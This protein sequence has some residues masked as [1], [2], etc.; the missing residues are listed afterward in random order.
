VRLGSVVSYAALLWGCACPYPNSPLL[1]ARA[2]P[3]SH[4]RPVEL[5]RDTKLAVIGDVQRTSW[6]ERCL[7]CR[8]LN[9]RPQRSLRDD[10]G[11]REF[12]ALVLLGDMAF[13]GSDEDW[14][15][16]DAWLAPLLV[17]R[18][19]LPLVP[20][21]GNHDYYAGAAPQV[22]R[23]FPALDGSEGASRYAVRWG[24]VR[25][26]VLD[27][28]RRK[29]E[30]SSPCIRSERVPL[31]CNDGWQRQLEWLRRE[32]AEVDASSTERGA[33]LFVH[34]SPYTRSPWVQP[35]QHDA[36]QVAAELFRSRRGLAL[37]SA[38]AH[39]F[40]R[41]R[42]VRD[43]RDLRAP[44]YFLVSAGGGGPRPHA[45]RHDAPPDLS[46]LGWPRPFHY[47]ILE[48]SAARVRVTVHAL[49][50]DDA[51]ETEELGDEASAL[52]FE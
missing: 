50:D 20:V 47:L 21:M 42:Y 15:H 5:A 38:H 2:E 13:S 39:G 28:N 23:R 41:Y 8:E 26:L 27:G 10:L 6:A 17:S 9:D 14:A 1:A 7:L 43:R 30:G 18:P 49:R 3:T 35:D 33:I 4:A 45:P 52:E 29:I 37:I 51:R 24:A 34:Q 31:S 22:R 46:Q 32:L 16:F 25:L 19:G 11:R 48:Q 44:K 36:R 12:G 40:E